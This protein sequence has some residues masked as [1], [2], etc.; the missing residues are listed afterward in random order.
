MFFDILNSFFSKEVAAE[1]IGKLGGVQDILA[2]LRAFPSSSA[3]AGNCCGA[4]WSLS[5]NEGNAKIVTEEKGLQD[6]INVF[7]KHAEQSGVI[8]AA[9]SALW[10]LSMEGMKYVK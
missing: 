5:V 9:C 4:L 8:E 1:V 2:A 10:S 6:V 3:I 7:E